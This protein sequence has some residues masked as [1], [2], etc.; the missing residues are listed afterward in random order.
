MR[1]WHPQST[2]NGI[3]VTPSLAV[4]RQGGLR[5]D[6]V[7]VFFSGL[8]GRLRL[9]LKRRLQCKSV[10][11][12]EPCFGWIVGSMGALSFSYPLTFGTRFH[13]ELENLVLC[14]MRFPV[15]VGFGT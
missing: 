8:I 7:G 12:H 14:G 6:L 4:A 15:V 1:P 13:L 3:R 5:Q 10:M 9:S 11:V 2:A